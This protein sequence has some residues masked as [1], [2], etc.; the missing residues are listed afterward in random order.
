M[1]KESGL[2]SIFSNIKRNQKE[3]Y[4]VLSFMLLEACI[5][6]KKYN[7]TTFTIPA[8]FKSQ[9]QIKIFEAYRNQ[10]NL[11]KIFQS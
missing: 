1:R 3:I 10:V 7:Q 6:S 5:K 4:D 11:S 9:E 2:G 8:A